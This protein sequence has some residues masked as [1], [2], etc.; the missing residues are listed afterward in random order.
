M[1]DMQTQPAATT[2]EQ[3][4][5]LSQ[6]QRVINTFS[7][8]SKTF[9]DIRDH[10][11]S[12]WLPFVLL[13]IVGTSLY[14]T[15]TVKVGWNQVVE[16][17]LRVAPKQAER[18]ESLT[19]EQR[20]TQARIGGIIQNVIWALGPIWVLVLNLIAAGILLGTINFGF[21][22]RA[23]YGQVLAVAWYAGLPG[24]LKL[25]LGVIGLW[26]GV[27]PESFLPGNPAG[28][29]LG[30]YFT[31]PD[32]SS[33]VWA[34]LTAFDVTAIWSMIL[35]AIGLSKVAGTKPSSGYI[36]VFGWFVIVLILQVGATAAFS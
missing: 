26:V 27:A 10:S 5:G 14:A 30:F 24:L 20:A 13:V 7:A 16:N 2:P 18:L 3:G 11:R 29:N 4:A 1:S 25:L 9:T 36:A 12:W 6:W 28:T 31:P 23:K 8:P 17:G 32:T 35:F 22:G 19:P 34:L 33:V 15:V 21:G